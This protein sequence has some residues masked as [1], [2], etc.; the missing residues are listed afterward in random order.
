MTRPDP[1]SSPNAVGASA[2]ATPGLQR[3]PLAG[4]KPT[5]HLGAFLAAL[6]VTPLT[7]CSPE[8][9]GAASGAPPGAPVVPGPAA[10]TD[11]AA[12]KPAA[13]SAP[14]HAPIDLYDVHLQV[15]MPDGEPAPLVPV[16]FLDTALIPRSSLLRATGGAP[17]SEKLLEI[18]GEQRMTDSRGRATFSTS[19]GPLLVSASFGQLFVMQPFSPPAKD[20]DP[21]ELK[22]AIDTSVRARAVSA[23]GTP[24]AGIPIALAMELPTEGGASRWVDLA[25]RESAGDDATVRFRD[26]RGG[27]QSGG[28]ARGTRF[29]LRAAIPGLADPTPVVFDPKSPPALPIDLQVPPLSTFVVEVLDTSGQ[30]VDLDADVI[31]QEQR[32]AQGSEAP[33]H[34]RGSKLRARLAEGR[35]TLSAI[36]PGTLL[37]VTVQP[38]DGS[39]AF[40]GIGPSALVAGDVATI[41]VSIDRASARKK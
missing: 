7:G 24:I 30:R 34:T 26:P 36:V 9:G 15:T 8:D 37:R 12:G 3:W 20:A 16:R 22:L 19:G 4:L 27:V 14:K 17:D 40:D 35:A 2:H 41:S 10:P 13:K 38:L 23:E 33:A 31:V 18:L 11:P 28:G 32:S 25:V 6:V 1:H 29:G 5:I 39:P 21:L